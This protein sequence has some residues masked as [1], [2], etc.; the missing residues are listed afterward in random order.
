M[1]D[2]VFM[3][4]M[5]VIHVFFV[6][7]CHDNGKTFYRERQ[8]NGKTTQK[9]YDVGHKY[10][11]DWS[12]I[13]FWHVMMDIFIYSPLILNSSILEDYLS[14]STPIVMMKYITS[15]VTILPK[16]EN[17]CDENFNL[18]HL[19][20]GHC[21]DK[22]FSGHFAGSVLISLL[23]FEKD[24][25]TDPKILIGYNLISAFLILATR[26]HYTVDIL[27]GGY[28]AITSYLLGINIDF[29]KNI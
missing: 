16:S 10:L 23:L 19:L 15:N 25:V 1:D 20:H 11:P 28:V 27:I 24:I 8:K 22:I 9:I 14:Y 12:H 7:I 18:I 21:Y 13:D 4:I 2:I 3:L 5:I 17:C 6:Y 26:S 29:V